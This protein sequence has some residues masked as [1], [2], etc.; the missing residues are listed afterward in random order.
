VA[1]ALTDEQIERLHLEYSL[2]RKVDR[3][4]K[5][6]GVSWAAAKKYLSQPIDPLTP[7]SQ[8]REQKKIDIAQKLGELQIVLIDAL[9]REDKIAKASFQELANTLGISI[10]KLQLI[11]GQ[12]TERHEHRDADTPRAELA[13]RIDELAE[14]RRAKQPADLADTAGS[15]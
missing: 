5:A 10:E 13:R 3:A 4:A 1:A 8:V 2:T 15:R 7:L 12:A 9:M 6:A 14:R 11:T